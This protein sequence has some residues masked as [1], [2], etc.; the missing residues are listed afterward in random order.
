MASSAPAPGRPLRRA[1]PPMGRSTI[2]SVAT[3]WRRATSACPSSWRVTDATSNNRKATP[4]KRLS[5]LRAVSRATQTSSSTKVA[6]RRMGIPKILPT[7]SAHGLATAA[8]IR[9]LAG[10]PER[11][12]ERELGPA[13]VRSRGLPA[14]LLSGVLLVEPALDGREVVLDR[15]GVHLRRAGE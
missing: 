3:P 9:A 10:A 12:P 11:T 14:A 5:P 13:F 7:C 4:R 15:A 6:C 8:L 1:T 2:S